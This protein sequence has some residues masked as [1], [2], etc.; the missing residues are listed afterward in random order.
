MA[1]MEE[2][3]RGDAGPQVR[4]VQSRLDELGHPCD[5]D[6]PAV[7]G[8][9]TEA[10]VRAFQQRRGLT[11][12]GH[13]DADT[14]RAIIEA[15]RSLGDRR[16]YLTDPLLRGDDVRDVQQRLNQL[17]FDAGYVDGV[18]G[19]DTA[20]AVREF[21]LNAGLRVDGIVGNE[22]VS[23]LRR[24]HRQHQ[25]ASAA[26]VRER[27]ALRIGPL[28]Q[29]LTGASILVDPGHGP[30]DPGITVDDGGAEH[31]VCWEVAS[32][33]EG[34]LLARGARV[35][36]SRGPRTSPDPSQRARL[37]NAEDV[38]LILS[39]HLNGLP[40]SLARGC[41]AYYF[42]DGTFV[43]EAGRRFA[44]LAVDAVV[45][46]TGTVHCRAHTS[47]VAL[48]RESRAPAVI[49]E[50]GFLTHPDEGARLR[51]PD[52]QDAVAEALTSAVG[53]YLTGHPIGS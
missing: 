4:D 50:P 5:P 21:E 17:G 48:L 20:A 13:V 3:R 2:I 33:V 46:R 19:P 24:L 42:G 51:Q 29:T 15:G 1:D 53:T 6:E 40:G 49:V 44:R 23:S 31:R 27:A 26:S 39:V 18:Y 9:A 43:S 35:V 22:V 10:A 28:R 45:A 7:F 30:D 37:A 52:Y 41:A 34:R 25:S 14:W 38:E 11:A 32:R 12:S 36:L 16:L 8:P 47:T